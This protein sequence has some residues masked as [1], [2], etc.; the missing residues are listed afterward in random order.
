MRKHFW[1]TL[2]LIAVL[3]G[4]VWACG[5]SSDGGGDESGEQ[6]SSGG[7]DGDLDDD[8]DEGFDEGPGDS[9]EGHQS[10]RELLGINPP[11]QPWHDMSHADRE[12]DM[13][14][15]FHPIFRE[16]FVEHDAEEFAEFGCADC[17]GPDMAETHF[18]MPSAH[19]PPIPAADS[20]EYAALREAHAG[21]MRFMEEDVTPAMQTM[22]GEPDF[23]CNGCHPTGG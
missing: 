9:T 20:A 2:S 22:L 17:H 16:F 11:E 15:R 14:G 4:S 8:L 13:V 3:G 18:E 1:L 23:S 21:M 10:A 6:A 5:G 7:E 19:L 12:M